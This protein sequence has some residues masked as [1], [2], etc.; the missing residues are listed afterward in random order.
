MIGVPDGCAAPRRPAVLVTSDQESPQPGREQ[1]GRR[2]HRHQSSG[3]GIGVEPAIRCAPCRVDQRPSTA[4]RG[5]AGMGPWPATT[6]GSMG[7]VAAPVGTLAVIGGVFWVAEERLARHDQLDLHLDLV[8]C[9]LTGDALDQGCPPSAD[10]GHAPRPGP[11]RIGSSGEGGE[12]NDPLRHREQRRQPRHAV[13]R[14]PERHTTIGLSLTGPL[15]ERIRIEPVDAS[16]PLRPRRPDHSTSP[17]R[18]G[19]VRRPPAAD[20]P[21]AQ[22]RGLFHI[23]VARHSLSWPAAGAAIVCGISCTS[24]SARPTNRNRCAAIRVAQ[25]HLRG[26]VAA[27]PPGRKPSC[28]MFGRLQ[29]AV[30]P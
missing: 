1:S 3:V 19:P 17:S 5:S 10:L 9:C 28:L 18:I 24:A 16:G 4:G 2:L 29:P 11:G 22:A 26:D 13:G 15:D 14:G 23:S 6:A 30:S 12:G 27:T 20:V 7:R 21:T 25:A 8:G